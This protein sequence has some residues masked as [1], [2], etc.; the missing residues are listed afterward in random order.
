MA[1]ISTMFRA[2]FTSTAQVIGTD[3]PT[4]SRG[5]VVSQGRELIWIFFQVF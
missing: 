2:T 4:G 3:H 5:S 1:I